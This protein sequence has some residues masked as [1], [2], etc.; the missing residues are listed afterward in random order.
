MNFHYFFTIGLEDGRRKTE[1]RSPKTE[2]GRRKTEDG[3]QKSEDGSPK[4]GDGSRKS[5]DRGL[6]RMTNFHTVVVFGTLPASIN[7]YLCLR[8]VAG[9]RLTGNIFV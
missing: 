9:R 6:G 1:V 4:S 3:S 8:P 7:Y 2:D 5:E